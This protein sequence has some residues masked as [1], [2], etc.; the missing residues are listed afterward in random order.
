MPKKLFA[1]TFISLLALP[2][3]GQDFYV[4]ENGVTVKCEN[5]EI[6]D[7][8]TISETTFTKRT[9]DQITTENA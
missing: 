5:A 3:Y 9:K 8:A 6:G 4:A 2:L 1:I 7:S